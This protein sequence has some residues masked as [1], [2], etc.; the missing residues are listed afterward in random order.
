MAMAPESRKVPA[1][2]FNFFA[3]GNWKELSLETRRRNSKKEG[4]SGV[5]TD[6]AY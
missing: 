4:Y 1:C 6:I 5:G 3:D 2:S